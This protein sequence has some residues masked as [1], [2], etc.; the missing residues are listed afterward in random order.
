MQKKGTIYTQIISR[1]RHIIGKWTSQTRKRD[2]NADDSDIYS[3]DKANSE[4][5]N[6]V[7][8]DL[9]WTLYSKLEAVLRGH[10]FIESCARRIKKVRILSS[11]IIK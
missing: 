3:L 9:L 10:R 4:V 8:K 11:W 7:L 1:F 5:K 2:K 6:E